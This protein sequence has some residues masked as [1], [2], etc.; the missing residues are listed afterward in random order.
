[1]LLDQ[2]RRNYVHLGFC[3]RRGT[4]LLLEYDLFLQDVVC[5][6][7]FGNI[8]SLK[9]RK[10]GLTLFKISMKMLKINNFVKKHFSSIEYKKMKLVCRKHFSKKIILLKK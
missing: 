5:V 3:L 10:L 9:K 4:T 6:S 7:W 8:Y 2:Y 1:M